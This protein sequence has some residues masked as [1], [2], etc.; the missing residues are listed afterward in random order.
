M[1]PVAYPYLIPVILLCIGGAGYALYRYIQKKQKW[2]N[3]L[4][5]AMRNWK[6]DRKKVKQKHIILFIAL[7]FLVSAGVRPQWGIRENV[8]QYEGLDIVF[9]LDVSKSMNALDFSTTR[10]Q[11]NR[12]QV[13][14]ELIKNFVQTRNQDR[15]GL[16]LFAGESFVSVPITFDREVFFNFLDSAQEGDVT[17]PGTNIAEALGVALE[18]LTVRDDEKRGKAIVLITDGD[19]TVNSE[20]QSLANISAEKQIPIFSVGIGSTSGVRIPEGTDVFG[21]VLYK[22]YKGH[23]VVTK[24]NEE[25]LKEIASLSGGKYFHAEEFHDLNGVSEA[26]NDLPKAIMEKLNVNLREDRYQIFVFIGFCAFLI[27]LFFPTGKVYI[28]K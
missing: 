10:Q 3:R 7:L 27:Y 26:L 8:I 19:E 23:D 15:F 16:I 18:R 9:V 5:F 20:I 12:L 14:K 28:K 11:I 17:L 2:S 6:E 24:L 4:L 25:V 1:I 21:R 22:Q 13:S